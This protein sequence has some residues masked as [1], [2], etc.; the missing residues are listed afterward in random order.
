MDGYH[1]FRLAVGLCA[2]IACVRSTDSVLFCSVLFCSVLFCSVLFCSVAR[3]FTPLL[4]ELGW[5]SGLA[6]G[7]EC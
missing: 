1:G 7:L 6:L 5:E 2:S 3:Y 4:V